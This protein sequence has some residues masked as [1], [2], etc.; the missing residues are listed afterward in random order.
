MRWRTF[1]DLAGASLFGALDAS[2]APSGSFSGVEALAVVLADSPGTAGSRAR[3]LA[4]SA[5]VAN[6][7]RSYQSCRYAEVIKILPPLLSQ[8]QAASATLTGD[9]RLKAQALSAGACARGS[10]RGD[11]ADR[12]G[13]TGQ[14][15]RGGGV[16]GDTDAGEEQAVQGLAE[17]SGN[18]AVHECHPGGAGTGRVGLQVQ[19]AFGYARGQVRLAI[20]PVIEGGHVGR[21]DGDEGRVAAER[22]VHAHPVKLVA[23]GAR[24]G[25]GGQG[26]PAYTPGTSPAT[27]CTTTRCGRVMPRRAT[28]S[29]VRSRLSVRPRAGSIRRWDP[30]VS[31]TSSTGRV[32]G[33]GTS[34]GT[35]CS[36]AAPSVSRSPARCAAVA[37]GNST[38]PASVWPA[39][40]GPDA[41]SAGAPPPRA[42]TATGHSCTP[43]APTSALTAASGK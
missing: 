8:V 1:A 14:A 9:G 6:A 28:A 41:V 13:G 34:T 36:Q 40:A 18:H 33:A 42:S 2:A 5:P 35:P 24:P 31:T 27:S 38:G 19:P 7:K 10:A 20:G 43:S 37:S 26:G 25:R 12:G 17:Q 22:L 11:V 21:G 16:L 15:A 3:L 39:A 30:R 32:P 4:L 29:D 23:Q